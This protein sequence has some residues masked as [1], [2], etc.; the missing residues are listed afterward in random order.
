MEVPL[1]R[2]ENSSSQTRK[3]SHNA[4]NGN[5]RAHLRMGTFG[6]EIVAQT[7]SLPYRRFGI[8]GAP[9]SSRAFELVGRLRNAI[10]RYGRLKICATLAALPDSASSFGDAPPRSICKLSAEARGVHAA[11]A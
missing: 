5:S 8:G 2:R 9:A 4:L 7:C 3:E 11:S 6:G 1:A 10:P